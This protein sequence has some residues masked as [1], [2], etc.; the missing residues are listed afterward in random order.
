MIA[1]AD[2]ASVDYTGIVLSQLLPTQSSPIVLSPFDGPESIRL[3]D[4]CEIREFPL[5]PFPLDAS[6]CEKCETFNPL[7]IGL[8]RG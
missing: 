4:A 1:V 3:R 7:D 6:P 5:F 8:L 2:K